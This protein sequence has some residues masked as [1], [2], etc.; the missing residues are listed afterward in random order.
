MQ[1]KPF[2]F[3]CL[4][5]VARH[6]VQ[7]I[8]GLLGATGYGRLEP[9]VEVITESVEPLLG[10]WRLEFA[11]SFPGRSADISVHD[12]VARLTLADATPFFVSFNTQLVEGL[13][14]ELTKDRVPR[15]GKPVS[16]ADYG[17]LIFILLQT[18]PGL[19]EVGLP[20]CLVDT[21]RPHP[22]SIRVIQEREDSAV[23]RWFVSKDT[24]AGGMQIIGSSAVLRRAAEPRPLGFDHVLGG[25]TQSYPVYL[26]RQCLAKEDYQGLAVGDV[27]FVGKTSVD[28]PWAGCMRLNKALV[29]GEVLAIEG[30]FGFRLNDP[31]DIQKEENMEENEHDA[32]SMLQV[33]EVNVDVQVGTT[34]MSLDALARLQAG[35]IVELDARIGDPVQLQVNGQTFGRGELVNV[36]GRLG[37]RVLSRLRR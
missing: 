13:L 37:V 11:G 15:A 36:E 27:L 8:N 14:L 5:V 1:V 2:P 25:I 16:D 19:R 30:R 10:R 7:F 32:T 22:E 4:E 20:P 24:L 6:D 34:K 3:D 26:G 28:G 35:S 31:I 33:A 29:A 17:A 21:V 18:L 9:M 23:L 12:F